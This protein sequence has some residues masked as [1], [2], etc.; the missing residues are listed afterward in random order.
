MDSNV[1]PNYECILKLVKK[2]WKKPLKI[3]MY[4]DSMNE[5]P[6]N[7]NISVALK[8]CVTTQYY[9]LY[10][11]TEVVRPYKKIELPIAFL[12]SMHNSWV[13]R[14]RV[15]VKSNLASVFFFKPKN[16]GWR[17]YGYNDHTNFKN[18]GISNGEA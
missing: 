4:Y 9:F 17:E 18:V 14:C 16:K 1:E 10:G 8:A 11:P 12:T 13:N 5:R 2:A 3:E 6:I 7:A 15:R